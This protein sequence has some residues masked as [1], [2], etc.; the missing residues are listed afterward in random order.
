MIPIRDNVASSR[1]PVVNWLLIAINVGVFL[2]QLFMMPAYAVQQGHRMYG[3][4]PAYLFG[5]LG[6]YALIPAWLT[7]FTS[8]FRH[9]GF[10]HIFSNMLYLWVFGDNIEDELGHLRYLG[11]YLSSGAVGAL[12]HGMMNMNS[13]TPLIGASG[14]IAGILGAYFILYPKARI[15]S[16]VPVFIIFFTVNVP[17]VYF[18]GA[19]FVLQVFNNS[20]ATAVSTTAYLAH[21]GGF[22]V[23]AVVG[24]WLRQK[25]RHQWELIPPEADH[26][27]DNILRQ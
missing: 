24:I 9:A 20:I 1:R 19:W 14:A 7:V 13:T 15:R 10:S 12:L 25:R 2:W 4:T 18:L 23:G 27:D 6:G 16:L 5:S 17:A 11:F 3:F 26:P 8:Q 21:I 22:V